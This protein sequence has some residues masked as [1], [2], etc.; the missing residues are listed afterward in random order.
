MGC[1][2]KYFIAEKREGRTEVTGGQGRRCMQLLDDLTENRSY[3][4]L[5]EEAAHSVQ[6]MLWKGYGS[7][8][9]ERERGGGEF[10]IYQ[11]YCTSLKNV[12]NKKLSPVLNNVPQVRAWFA[13][14]VYSDF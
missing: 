3:W 12:K 9:R 7:Y 6:K 1:L 2:L 14:A 10:V 13:R 11:I 5:N 8:V 4:N